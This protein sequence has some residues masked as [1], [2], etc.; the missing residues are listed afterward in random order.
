MMI[1]AINKAVVIIVILLIIITEIEIHSNLQVD[2]MALM[3]WWDLTIDT[4]SCIN[5]V[6]CIGLCVD[7]SVHIALHF[8]QVL[9]DEMCFFCGVFVRSSF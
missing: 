9:W 5:L 7:Y 2:V 1:S 3:T 4:V 6:L 8:M